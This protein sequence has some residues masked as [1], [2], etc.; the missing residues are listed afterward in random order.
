MNIESINPL[1]LLMTIAMVF[2]IVAH[3]TNIDRA[4]TLAIAVPVIAV[5]YS[6]IEG[7]V[8]L[9]EQQLHT[10]IEQISIN[11]TGGYASAQPRVLPRDDENSN[12]RKRKSYASDADSEYHW[13]SI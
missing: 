9:G 8:N 2:G 1:P 10:H 4:A 3:D 12:G 6:A 7:I 13:P 5:G 11:S